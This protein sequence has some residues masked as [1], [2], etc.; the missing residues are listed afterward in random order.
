MREIVGGTAAPLRTR[1]RSVPCRSTEK[2]EKSVLG[3]LAQLQSKCRDLS[4]RLCA[5]GT[6]PFCERLATITP[7]PRY[8]EMGHRAGYVGR[9][10]RTFAT[11]VHVGMGS[12]DEAIT[13]M[14][15]LKAYLPLLV[16]LSAGSPFWRGYETGYASYR[17]RILAAARSYG[18][19]PSF[20]DWQHFCDFLETSTRAGMFQSVHDIHWDI[21]PRPHLGTLEVRVMDAMPS[22]A[23][24]VAMAALV[25]ALVVYLSEPGGDG[26]KGLPVPLPWWTEKENHFQASRDGLDAVFVRDEMGSSTSLRALFADVARAVRPT[27]EQ[28]GDGQ[29]FDDLSGRVSS[30]LPYERQLRRWADAGS[31]R[32]VA[33]MLVEE[34]EENLA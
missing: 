25:R 7:L 6:H 11:H 10:L 22:V 5:G 33:Q 15:R 2:L 29:H 34:L 16:S 17:Q 27:A 13:V 19:P 3:I 18:I 28:L 12:G 21:R 30:G 20:R 1:S 23:Q 24:A 9:R 31:T 4:L 8:I 26:A 32:A 14:R